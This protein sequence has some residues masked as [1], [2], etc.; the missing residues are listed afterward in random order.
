MQVLDEQQGLPKDRC[1]FYPGMPPYYD[2]ILIRLFEN[3]NSKQ[4]SLETDEE[5]YERT[6]QY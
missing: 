6:T 1:D 2:A 5:L 4:L 3:V